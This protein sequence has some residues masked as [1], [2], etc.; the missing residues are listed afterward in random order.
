MRYLGVDLHKTNFVVCFLSDDETT[1]TETYPLTKAGITRFLA[2]LE[3]EDQVAVEVTANIYYF[4]DQ[5]KAACRP[6]RVSRH[7]SLRGH[8]QIEEEDGQGGCRSTGPLSQA[9]VVASGSRALGAGQTT[10]TPLASQRDFGG[11]AYQAQEYGT[12][13]TDP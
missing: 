6:R 7:L 2:Q 12:R 11:D 13:R 3:P 5:V 1:Q 4:Y 8:R 9:G 10:A